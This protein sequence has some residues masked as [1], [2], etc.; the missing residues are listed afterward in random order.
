MWDTKLS[1]LGVMNVNIKKIV[2]P[3]CKDKYV[4]KDAVYAHMDRSHQ[5]EI[6]DDIP[7]DKFFYD[8]THKNVK[9]TGCV[10]C[11][12][13]TPWNPKTHKYQ[14]VCGSDACNKKVRA[15]FH[16]RMM[17]KYKTDN[18]ASDPEHQRKMLKGRRISGVYKWSTGG[19]TDYVGTYELDFL[20]FCDIVLDF[21]ATDLFSPSPNTYRYEYEGKEHFYIPDFFIPTLN[22]EVEIKDGGDNPNMHHKIQSVDKVKEKLKDYIMAKQHNFHYIKV[23]DKKYDK[24]VKLV[25]KLSDDDLSEEEKVQKIKV[26]S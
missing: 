19:E 11:H 7:I 23:V 25:K 12:K 13:D 3:L 17:K 24:F 9:R 26:R 8:L 18:L 16:E 4:S 20:K 6:P 2:C 1:I 22:L 15:I 14:R 5:N 10:I 21:K